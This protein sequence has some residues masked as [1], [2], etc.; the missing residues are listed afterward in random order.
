MPC[1]VRVSADMLGA[2]PVT[3]GD[4][5]GA[6]RQRA[7]S[8]RPGV[9]DAGPLVEGHRQDAEVQGRHFAAGCAAEH[10]RSGARPGPG[11][12][13]AEGVGVLA[14]RVQAK[15]PAHRG[16]RDQPADGEVAAADDDLG[17]GPEH[18]GLGS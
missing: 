18:P 3:H 6:G 4:R 9:A 17:A 16:D 5:R 1:L 8:P 11:D 12:V 14:V 15:S 10:D 13:D 7:D 2:A